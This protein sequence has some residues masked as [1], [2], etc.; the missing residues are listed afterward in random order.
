MIYPVI[1]ALLTAALPPPIAL[2]GEDSLQIR[3]VSSGQCLDVPGGDRK[4]HLP[5]QQYDCRNPEDAWVTAQLWQL[6]KIGDYVQIQNPQSDRCLDIPNGL[7]E[8]HVTV[9]QYDC[10]HP[11]DRWLSAQLWQL[12]RINGYVQ[13]RNLRTGLCLDMPLG[14][15]ENHVIVQQYTC[16]EL[17]DR[18]I[19]SQLWQLG[20]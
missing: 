15:A 1:I 6:S 8:N 14:K 11:G 12:E 5:I 20:Q 10:R 16:R 2:T 3:N 9:Q 19:R 13:I 7:A 18:W 4:N 17:G